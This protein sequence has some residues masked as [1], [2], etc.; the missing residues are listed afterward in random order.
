MLSHILV[1]CATFM[2]ILL[3]IMSFCLMLHIE[4]DCGLNKPALLFSLLTGVTVSMVR[5]V[6]MKVSRFI[7]AN[8]HPVSCVEAVEQRLC[9]IYAAE[10]RVALDRC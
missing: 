9:S 3:I 1:R 6:R 5:T 7:L 2:A 10:F 4:K 8:T